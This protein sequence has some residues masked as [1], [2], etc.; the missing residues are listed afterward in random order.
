MV[1]I[2]IQ[3]GFQASGESRSFRVNAGIP[4]NSLG[5]NGDYCV[6]TDT[7]KLYQ[8]QSGVYVEV[9]TLNRLAS[10]Q[11][12]GKL[13]LGAGV[14]SNSLGSNKDW[15]LNTTNGDVYYREAGVYSMKIN[16]KGSTGN[17]AT[18]GSYT[19]AT[20]IYAGPE[21]DN[22]KDALD[23][24]CQLAFDLNGGVEIP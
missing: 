7:W 8:K 24:L 9:T 2:L 19:P 1:D 16:V 10:L 18:T 22:V 20:G 21:P 17:A 3:Y 15:Y 11:S 23:R 13:W 12:R 5:V 4:S 6:D 14:P